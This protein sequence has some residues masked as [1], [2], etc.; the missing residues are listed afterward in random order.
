[1][2]W[3]IILIGS[4]LMILSF[5]LANIGDKDHDP[6]TFI[7][8]PVVLAF[9]GGLISVMFGIFISIYKL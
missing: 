2:G 8:V 3:K 4:V 9:Y 7:K 5:I 1:M 6:P